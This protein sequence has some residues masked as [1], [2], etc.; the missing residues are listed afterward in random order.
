MYF[1]DYD[2]Q[3]YRVQVVGAVATF[4]ASRGIQQL[5][6]HPIHSGDHTSEGDA[7]GSDLVHRGGEQT[8]FK[9]SERKSDRIRASPPESPTHIPVVLP[10]PESNVHS[11]SPD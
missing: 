2:R 11:T 6:F 9:V 3:R 8:T 4:C 1:L 5:F 10:P 7:R